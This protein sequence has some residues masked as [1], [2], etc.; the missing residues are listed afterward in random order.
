MTRLALFGG[1]PIRTTP[2]PAPNFI[3]RE[4]RLAALEVLES[5]VLSRFLGAWHADFFGGARVQGFEHAWADFLGVRHAISVNSAASGLLAAVGAAGIGPGDEVICTPYTMSATATAI[6][7]YGG[8]PV[9]ADIEADTFCLDPNDV[10]R[11]ITPRTKAIMV[12]HLFGHPADM[13]AILAIAREHHL[14]TIEDAAQAPGAVYKGRLV[15]G[16]GDMTVFSLNYH[17]HIHTGE[18]GVVTTNNAELAER[19]QLIRNHGEAVVQDKGVGRLDNTYGFNFRMTEITAAI[20][21]EQLKK[22]P[23]LLEAR[24]RNAEYLSQELQKLPGIHPPVVRPGC[25]HVY[26][27]QAFLFDEETIGVPRHQFVNAIVAELP[28]AT[29][30]DWPLINAGYG[31]PLYFLPM[32]QNRIAMGRSGFPF[33]LAQDSTLK[34]Y[35]KGSCPITE[36]I[37]D[38]RIIETEFMRPPSTVE[39]MKDVVRAFQKVYEQRASLLETSRA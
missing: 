11:K 18:G 39:D 32:F 31:K 28:T 15:G 34:S 22:L 13:D 10:Q 1:K 19:L 37:E 33:Q 23:S 25:K 38:H 12:V 30:R 35:R 20:G 9:F 24:L 17:K 26:Y 29:D 5:G 4:E 36:E 2:F 14:L 8:L 16:L 21:I 3:G 27:T 7:A 6:I